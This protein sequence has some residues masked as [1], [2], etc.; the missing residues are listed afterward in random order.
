MVIII[1]NGYILNPA[2]GREGIF[3]ILIED[4]VIQ[5]IA[6]KITAQADRIID[7]SNCYVMPGFIDLHVHLREPGFEYK[8]TIATGTRAAAAGGYTTI[9]P[10]PNTKPVIDCAEMVEFLKQKEQK[11]ASVHLVCISAVTKGQT[12]EELVDFAEMAKAGALAVSEDGKS[13]M[14][15]CLYKEGMKKAAK[16]GLLV[17]AHCEEKSLVGKG[18]MNEG[19][20]AEE[21]GL[22]GISNSVED[23]ITARDIILAKETGARLHLCHCSTAGSVA[24]IKL[25]KEQKISVTAEVC[26]H[27]FSMSDEEILEDDGNYKMN[28]PL[29][30]PK[31]VIALKEGLR[32]GI[33]DVISTD[34]APHSTEEKCTS[35]KRAPFGIV[36][37]ETA[38][39]LTMTHLVNTGYLTPM[40]MV[41]KMSWKPA[42]ILKLDRGNLSPGKAADIVIADPKE[43][44]V[45]DTSKF[46][47]KG[48]N[49]PFH[50]HRVF[51]RVLFTLV[52]GKIVYEAQKAE[53]KKEYD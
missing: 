49:T 3:D 22:L 14:D 32:E 38:F 30:S 25:A 42:Q 7:A 21:L 28:P 5:G 31:D 29:R 45:I 15:I 48:K 26:P 4:G 19:K 46:Y 44:Y 13:V 10:M 51:G 17:M 43:E 27:H 8:E 24:M 9:C 52:D 39:S 37:S 40:Q 2:D 35:M 34:H 11:E 1:Q 41:E 47:S 18:V 50:G 53:R 23:V 20:K 12:G 33:I 16:E 36:G 6:P